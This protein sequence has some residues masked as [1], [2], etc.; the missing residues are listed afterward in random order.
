MRDHGG[1]RSGKDRRQKASSQ[2]K[3]EKRLGKDRRGGSDRR[4]SLGDKR[5]LNKGNGVER[6]TVFREEME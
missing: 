5:I 4:S 3:V 2:S 1:T 6:R